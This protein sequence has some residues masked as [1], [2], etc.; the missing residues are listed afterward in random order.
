MVTV[1]TEKW[2][3]NAFDEGIYGESVKL[4]SYSY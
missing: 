1:L 4:S 3:G 2:L